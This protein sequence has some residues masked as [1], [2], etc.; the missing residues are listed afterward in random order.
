MMNKFGV[1]VAYR[2]EFGD[3]V[4]EISSNISVFEVMLDEYL[5]H[6]ETLKQLGEHKPLIAHSVSLSIGNFNKSNDYLSRIKEKLDKFNMVSYSDHLSYSETD[7]IQ[8][9]NF[10]NVPFSEEMLL[11]LTRDI[12]I[13]QGFLSRKFSFENIVY[14]FNWPKNDF[15]ENEFIS[16]L[17]LEAD[18]GLLLDISNLYI[19]SINHSYSPYEYIDSLPSDRIEYYHIGGFT[20]EGALLVDSHD[21]NI[22][23]E[24]WKLA[25]YAV[26]NTSGQALIIERDNNSTNKKELLNEISIAQSIWNKYK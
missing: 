10:I 9:N 1:G 16:K 20:K 13:V 17:L 4:N 19:N 7:D 12:K 14:F 26:R 18:C 22:D 24:V 3:Y 21:V 2:P 25:E 11:K 5:T 15:K 23:P 6:S 8:I